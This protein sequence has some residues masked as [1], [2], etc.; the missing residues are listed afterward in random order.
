MLPQLQ[1]L[2][3]NSLA[4]LS[5][6]NYVIVCTSRSVGQEALHPKVDFIYHLLNKLLTLLPQSLA[7]S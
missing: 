7:F 5:V 2:T 3:P 4:Y 6:A 1:R